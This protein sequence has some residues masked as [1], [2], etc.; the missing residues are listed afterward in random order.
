[1]GENARFGSESL[2]T[3]AETS[4]SGAATRSTKAAGE[5]TVTSRLVED[6]MAPLSAELELRLQPLRGLEH[7]LHPT[8]P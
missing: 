7:A 4:V 1:M 6:L 3:P 8:K 2:A 5:R